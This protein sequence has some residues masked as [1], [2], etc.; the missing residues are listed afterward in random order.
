MP[1]RL[2]HDHPA[3]RITW[4]AAVAIGE[5]RVGRNHVGWIARN[6]VE[7]LA[8][9]RCEPA[10][11]ARLQAGR[12]V[13]C[14]VERGEGEGARIDV[15]RDHLRAMPR[16]Q[17]SLHTTAAAEIEGPAGA[18]ADGEAGERFAGGHVAEHRIGLRRRQIA[19]D[20]QTVGRPDGAARMH[21]AVANGGDAERLEILEPHG[22]ER[23]LHLARLHRRAEPE[24]CQ[25][26]GERG[27][28][29]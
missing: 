7:A 24:Q 2:T 29:S 13:Q 22:R 16:Q 4:Q 20:E 12:L 5:G 19:G 8:G 1:G 11:L 18:A 15:D 28:L 27:T 17:Q 14:G 3:H 6:R 9:D 21:A 23:P 10:A 26:R 25:K